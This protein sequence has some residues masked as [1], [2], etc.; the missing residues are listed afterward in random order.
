[1]PNYMLDMTNEECD[2]E[3]YKQI[4]LNNLEKNGLL[5]IKIGNIKSNIKTKIKY[6]ITLLGEL[7][8]KKIGVINNE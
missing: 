7:I 5:K 6:E 3:T 4:T 8:L 1:M 2:S